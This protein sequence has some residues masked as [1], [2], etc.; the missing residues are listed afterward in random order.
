MLT[1]AS[2]N[3]DAAWASGWMWKCEN[4]QQSINEKVDSEQ[5]S[6]C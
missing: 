2:A 4:A 6:H 5:R 3:G 1:V